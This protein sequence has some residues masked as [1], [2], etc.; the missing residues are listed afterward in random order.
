M[1]EIKRIPKLTLTQQYKFWLKVKRAA[2]DDCWWWIGFKRP[3]GYGIVSFQGREYKAHR[4]SYFLEY[5]SIPDS[6]WVLHKCDVRSCVNPRHLYLGDVCDNALDRQSRGRTARQ[7]FESNGNA[8]LTKKAVR[9]IRRMYK[10][11]KWFQKD[12]AKYFGVSPTTICYVV[13]GG[14]WDDLPRT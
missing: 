11:G 4:I 9:A 3:S 14:R 10:T 12:L 5:G 2:K 8:K 7:I 1:L 6:K 13:N